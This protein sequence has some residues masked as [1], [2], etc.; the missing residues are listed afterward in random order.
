MITSSAKKSWDI[1][2]TSYKDMAKVNI[3]KLQNV[4][5]Y[6]ES[7]QMKE[8]NDIDSFTNQGMIV[9]NHLKIYGV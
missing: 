4:R 7:L 1:L 9:I 6:F 5:R 2:A 8:T 3:V